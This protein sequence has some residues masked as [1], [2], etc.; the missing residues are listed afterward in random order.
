MQHILAAVLVFLTS[1]LNF[2]PDHSQV[3][4]P[5]SVIKTAAESTQPYLENSNNIP[6]VLDSNPNNHLPEIPKIEAINT[7][8]GK[9]IPHELPTQA[10]ENS[11]ALEPKVTPTP[12]VSP[13]PTPEPKPTLTP[14][15][16]IFPNP[17]LPLPGCEQPRPIDPILKHPR[18]TIPTICLDNTPVL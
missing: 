18:M 1:F 13:T 15:P 7:R 6:Q 5:V 10:V 4:K 14:E 9:D 11:P 3:K 16:T 17:P 12:F 2:N 8:S